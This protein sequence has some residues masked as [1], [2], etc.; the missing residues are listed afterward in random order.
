[1]PRNSSDTER[2][3]P[4]SGAG[5]ADVTLLDEAMLAPILR[6]ALRLTS[7][8]NAAIVAMDGRHVATGPDAARWLS[9][10]GLRGLLLDCDEPTSMIQPAMSP[11][12]D[13]RAGGDHPA[14]IALIPLHTA[15]R[16]VGVLCMLGHEPCA[17]VEPA[18]LEDLA[19][20][21]TDALMREGHG[22]A[23]NGVRGAIA[24]VD[25]S[26]R[27][28]SWNHAAER[29]TGHAAPRAIGMP[30]ASL[31][32]APHDATYEQAVA[33]DRADP[34]TLTLRHAD[35]HDLAVRM[36]ALPAG[37]SETII[38][39]DTPGGDDPADAIL[40]HLPHPLFVK[41]VRTRRFVRVNRA[42]AALLGET[43][44]TLIGRADYELFPHLAASQSHEQP[45]SAGGFGTGTDSTFATRGGQRVHVRTRRLA[46]D[47][48][49]APRR[50]VAALLEDLSEAHRT[51]QELQRLTHFDA[52][53]GLFNRA[54]YL[55]RLQSLILQGTPLCLLAIALDRLK[56]A[57]D[58][59]GHL[60]GDMILADAG[61]RL[62]ALLGPDDLV[63]RVGGDEFAV[64][65]VGPDAALR[66]P[67]LAHAIS[68][69]MVRPFATMRG[70]AYLGAGIGGASFP[71]DATTAPELRRCCDAAL[72][73]AKSQRDGLVRFYH[74]QIDH[75]ARDRLTLVRD[76]REAM[77]RGEITLAY[78]PVFAAA[79][80]RITSVEALARWTHPMRG[81][82]SPDLFI[83][84]AE[85]YGLIVELGAE[86]LRRACADA[87]GWPGHVAVAVNLSPL[88]FEGDG[89]IATIQ[90][91]LATTGLPARRLHLEVTEGLV[92]H[93][94]EHTYRQLERLR[95]LGIKILMDDFGTGYSALSYFQRFPFDKVKIDQ[96]FVRELGTGRAAEAIV[97]AVAGLGKAMGMGV[98]AEGV[99][100]EEQMATLIA[101]GCTHVQGYLFSK[102]IP[103]E[104]LER[105]LHAQY[106]PRG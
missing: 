5:D 105:L 25:R 92:I 84:V 98:V 19:L 23:V 83:S 45:P 3:S 56:I 67:P 50:Y 32:L 91:V 29:L 20:M 102:P 14:F 22:H 21:V 104:S 68:A 78:Q 101:A 72:H 48:R 60:A 42:G 63:A 100:T 34:V 93:D 65:V 99:E 81:R 41:D 94:V 59:F 53:T 96:S 38:V 103:V 85:Q 9:D 36:I 89:L 15:G 49:D 51:E 73:R 74:K 55:D 35:G 52:L 66:A 6:T 27:I 46:I 11:A 75:D 71:D 37:P 86:L 7:A 90:N 54:T 64:V 44:E 47:G 17:P 31:L 4:A 61:E 39:F 26:G 13:G 106:A 79:T 24:R 82:V 16:R 2:R 62:C 97:R 70:T 8:E 77:G 12:G 18:V 43:A 87:A 69:E 28:T 76:L 95:E 1:M 58:Q 80:G 57:N 30:I 88:Q 33:A 10:D 40:E